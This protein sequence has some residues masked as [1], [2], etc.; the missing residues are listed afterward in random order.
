MRSCSFVECIMYMNKLKRASSQ[1]SLSWG[2]GGG[3]RQSQT[4]ILSTHA[5]K[6]SYSVFDCHLS[7]VGRQMAIKNSVSNKFDLHSCIVKSAFDCI[8]P[9]VIMFKRTYLATV[10]C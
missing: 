4:L 7:P 8:L 2:R 5:D 9:G 6:N 1:D 3:R 10:T